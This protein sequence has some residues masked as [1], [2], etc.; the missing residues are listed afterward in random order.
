[1]N[2]RSSTSMK[3]STS[4]TLAG[5]PPAIANNWLLSV[6]P[7]P[8]VH[9]CPLKRLNRLALLTAFAPIVLRPLPSKI[10]LLASFLL[11]NSWLKQKLMPAATKVESDRSCD[12]RATAALKRSGSKVSAL[13]ADAEV[14]YCTAASSTGL[15]PSAITV[16]TSRT[17]FFCASKFAVSISADPS[18]AKQTFALHPWTRRRRSRSCAVVRRDETGS[19][20]FLVGAAATQAAPATNRRRVVKNFIFKELVGKVNSFLRWVCDEIVSD[21]WKW[22]FWASGC[23]YID[24]GWLLSVW[25]VWSIRETA[26]GFR[27]LADASHSQIALL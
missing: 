18:I 25:V 13:I 27:R 21:W 6:K 15:D 10:I 19:M 11:L 16:T 22:R 26:M 12:V 1:M 17:K 5:S 24:D 9:T 3:L 7:A 2:C 14:P 8:T 20:S 4:N 23:S